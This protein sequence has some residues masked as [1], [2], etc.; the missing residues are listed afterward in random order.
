[1]LV[2]KTQ[3]TDAVA[4]DERISASRWRIRCPR[5]SRRTRLVLLLLVA[6]FI[7]IRAALPWAVKA[8]VNHQFD[9]MPD[10]AGRVSDVDIHLLRGAY[11]IHGLEI[12]KTDGH[13]PVPLFAA[14]KVDFSMEWKELFHGALVGEIIIEKPEVHFVAGPTP[15]ETQTGGNRSWGETLASLFPFK[16]NRVKINDGTIHFQN[17]HSTPPVDIHVGDLAATITNLTNTRDLTEQ[18]PAGLSARGTTLGGG[19]VEL[20]LKMNPLAPAPAFELSGQLTNVNLVALNDFLK[21]Y[22]KFD[23][24]RGTFA[25]FASFAAEDGKYEGYTKVFFENLDVFA[26][27]KE[28]KKNVLQIF[29]HAIVGGITTVFRNQPNDR[30]AAKIPVSGSFTGTDVGIWSAA[31]TLL[32]NAFIQALLPKLDQSVTLEEV[33]EKEP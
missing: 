14:R 12:L 15:E 7:V 2:L 31:G 6:F 4:S 33:R 28:R 16:F 17:F 18:L 29:W 27:E 9:K 26:W 20:H 30:L 1:M 5:I 10:Y 25:L 32:R 19:E 21:A 23:V 3:F 8:Y 13:V 22:G 24:E 11:Q